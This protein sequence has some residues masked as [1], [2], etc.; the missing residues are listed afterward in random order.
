MAGVPRRWTQAGELQGPFL[1]DLRQETYVLNS[2]DIDPEWDGTLVECRRSP[3]KD[4]TNQPHQSQ[5]RRPTI[6]Y[7][8]TPGPRRGGGK[9]NQ[10]PRTPQQ[11]ESGRVIP[12]PETT[13]E[14]RQ[15]LNPDIIRA[16]ARRTISILE[17]AVARV[18]GPIRSES[19]TSSLADL[20]DL[21]ED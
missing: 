14:S 9:E 13:P 8:P 4:V 2:E 6:T 18:Q 15:I 11:P 17:E 7:V 16:P 12:R 5:A 1:D 19:V 3:L 21:I 20:L 10:P